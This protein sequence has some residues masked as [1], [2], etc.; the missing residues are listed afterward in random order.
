MLA[1]T[2]PNKPL[3]LKVGEDNAGVKA[4][5]KKFVDAY[6]KLINTTND[7]T[8]VTK[9]GED[10]TPLVG[11]LVGD[12]TVRN[13]VGG[14]R[15][16]LVNP[17]GGDGV[18][19]LADLGITTQKDGTLKIED[20]KLDAA[21]KD[22]FDAVG[23]FFLGDTGLMKRLDGQVASYSQTGGILSQR[24]SALQSTD[25]DIKKQTEDL[26]LRVDSMQKRLL[27][28]FNAMDSLVGQLN[29]TSN[30]LQNTLSN[31]PGVVRKNN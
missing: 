6:N 31:L 5:I 17:V 24:M 30:Q 14:V 4:G 18:R 19:V 26:K 10:G 29:G 1:T 9:V 3:T 16:E 2:E 20:T 22:N 28:Q 27:A 21:L 7:L 23:S 11:G 25:A 12:S 15:N 13:L 8:R